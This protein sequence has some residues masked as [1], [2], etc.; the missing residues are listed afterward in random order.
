MLGVGA[1]QETLTTVL[2]TTVLMFDGDLGTSVGIWV[3]EGAE[4]AKLE[5]PSPFTAA[6][7]TP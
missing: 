1:V 7:S 4:V 2:P 5:V 6:T 3:I